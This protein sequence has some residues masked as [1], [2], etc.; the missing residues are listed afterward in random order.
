[1]LISERERCSAY[2]GGVVTTHGSYFVG[3]FN[4]VYPRF[5]VGPREYRTDDVPG[6]DGGDT[7][8]ELAVFVHGFLVSE[9]EAKATFRIVRDTL[10]FYGYDHPLVG[11]TWDS[12]AVTA[13]DDW[14]PTVTIARLN[15]KRLAAFLR[16][17]HR[18]NPDTA[19]RL[20]GHSLG[21]RI[22]LSALRRL[23]RNGGPTVE[24]VTLLGAAVDDDAPR[25]GG[26]GY[27]DGIAA[28]AD[29]VDNYHSR[30]DR[31]LRSYRLFEFDAPLGR[32]GS[33]G[34]TPVNY[35]DRGVPSVDDHLNYYR[36]RVGCMDSVLGDWGH[37]LD[38][39]D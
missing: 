28:G 23:T 26:G 15:G 36:K 32:V 27:G 13:V 1:M 19:I 22:V 39:G 33:E 30:N 29:A 7:P 17:Y 14:Y 16:D 12:D 3:P 8:E 24:N 25:L 4:V 18:E 34:T 6:F 37:P 21:V 5:G 35:A 11:F 31:Q 9:R 38:T 10:G 2:C 20:V